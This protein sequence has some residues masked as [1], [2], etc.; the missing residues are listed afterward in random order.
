MRLSEMAFSEWWQSQNKVSIFFNGASKGNP[1]IAGVGTSLYYHGGMLE[2]SFSLGIGQSTN[3]QVEILTLLK[4]YQLAKEAKHKYLQIF[5]DS[6]ILIKFLNTDKHFNNF[7]LNGTMQRIQFILTEF[8]LVSFFHILR[9]LNKKVDCKD[10][11]G[12]QLST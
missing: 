12:C 11:R 10:N 7:S 9:E 8:D 5:R 1:R 3:N 4:A 2:T 6:E